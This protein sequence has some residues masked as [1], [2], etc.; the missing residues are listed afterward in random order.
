MIKFTEKMED[1]IGQ[2]EGTGLEMLELAQRKIHK[3]EADKAELDDMILDCHECLLESQ[4]TIYEL[5]LEVS[6]LNKRR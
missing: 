3:L 5:R 4:K 1:L 2:L 6:R